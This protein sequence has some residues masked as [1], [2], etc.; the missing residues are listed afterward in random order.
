VNP[1][2]ALTRSE[3][4]IVGRE[5][6]LAGH[7]Q[8]RASIPTVLGRHPMGEALDL[9]IEEWMTASPVYTRRMQRLMRFEGDDVPTIFKG[10]QLDIGMPHQFLDA[11]Y[12]VR[13]ARHGEFW[14]RSCGALADVR[15][16]GEDMTRGMCHD[17]EDPTFD[18]TAATTNPRAQIRPIHRPP[19]RPH[20]GPDCHWTVTIDDSHPPAAHHPHL[21]QVAGSLVA[22]LP[23]DPPAGTEPGGWDDYA[24]PFD[25]HFELEDLSQRALCLVAREFAIQAHILARAAFLAIDRR[26]GRDEAIEVGRTLFTGI[27]WIAA[28]RM[29]AALGA[30]AG[31]ADALARVLPLVHL[32]LPADYLGIDIARP[33]AAS[34]VVRLAPDPPA[35]RE[36]DAYSLSSFLLGGA[37]EIVASL[38]GGVDPRARVDAGP[39]DD[40]GRH[41]RL[42]VPPGAEPRPSPEAANLVR[43]STGPTTVF[44]R[45]RPL[46]DD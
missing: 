12:R 36:G 4:A 40:G 10:I 34:V 1:L 5:L 45:R 11:G 37:D 39:T 9:A 3:L 8:D 14:L 46:R 7:L 35:L 23:N 2:A 19:E 31:G 32:L 26:Y 38:A 17:I 20:G 16:L 33:D 15:P 13:D 42:T 30:T 25:P 28:E 22:R 29:A 27:A 18:A 43:L 41:W 24:G 21:D 6:M 44:I